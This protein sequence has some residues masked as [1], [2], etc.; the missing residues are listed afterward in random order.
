MNEFIRIAA[1]GLGAGIGVSLL[2]ETVTK[3]IATAGGFDAASKG[4]QT[5]SS[6]IAAG[7]GVFAAEAILKAL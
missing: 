2:S 1:L 3:S 5:A 7:F 4:I 6:A